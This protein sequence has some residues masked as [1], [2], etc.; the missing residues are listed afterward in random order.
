M[1][2]RRSFMALALLAGALTF[3][4]C[5]SRTNIGKIN[6]DP[7]RYFDKE[8][9]VGGTVVDSYGVPFVGGAYEID[10]GTGKIWVLTERGTPSKG[11]RV[12]VKGRVVNGPTFKGRNFGVAMRETDRR[13][14]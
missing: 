13:S 14:R 5:P 12:G 10:D 11:A 3:A 4:A 8:V 1:V 2:S 6:A 9:G 7:Q